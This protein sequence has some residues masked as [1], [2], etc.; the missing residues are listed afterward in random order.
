M[1]TNSIDELTRRCG[2]ATEFQNFNKEHT[3]I[4]R[5]AQE[6][7]LSS[8][9]F[10]P[11]AEGASAA[12]TQL[13]HEEWSRVLPPII[14][15]REGET[16]GFEFNLPVA[17]ADAG[18][19]CRI[20]VEEGG[21]LEQHFSPA[22][23]V[24]VA[25]HED[26]GQLYVRGS[27]TLD[28]EVLPPGHHR[29]ALLAPSS[30][31]ELADTPL[32]IAQQT[33][34]EPEPLR[35][36]GK[37]FGTTMQLYTLRSERNWGMGDFTDLKNFIIAAAP[38]GVDI[39]GLNPLHALFPA[40][41]L[42]FS[43]YSPSNRAFINVMYIDAEAVPEFAA[44]DEAQQ[45]VADTEFQ[46]GLAELRATNNVDY[47]RV[48]DYKLAVLEL[49]FEWFN[50]QELP[51]DTQRALAY[52]SFLDEQGAMLRAHATYDAMHEY[53]MGQDSDLWGWPVWPA[54][55]RDPDSDA[56]ADFVEQ[57]GDRVEYFQYLQ[58]CAF[59]Q[60]RGAQQVAVDAGMAVGVYLDL[61]VGVADSGSEAWANQHLYCLKSSA[62]AP[63][64][65]LARE[66]QDWGFPPFDPVALKHDAYELFTHNLVS[67]M[68][69]AGAVRFDHCVSLM[70]LWWVPKG[71]TARQGGY[72]NYALQDILAVLA[73][74]SWR[75][76]C[77]VIGEDLGTVPDLLTEVMLENHLY[78]YR[79]LYFE[80]EED[81]GLMIK[82]QDYPGRAVATVSTHDLPTLASWWDESDI[83]IRAELNLLG[84]D[85][86]IGK[87]RA[88][89]DEDK[90][91]LLD[92]LHE[93]GHL[94]KPLLAD[95]VPVMSDALNEAVHLY[96]AS[97][98]STVMIAQLEDWL[99]MVDP[100]NIPGT[101]EEH[102][103][104]QRKMTGPLE[105]FFD[106]PFVSKL[107]N[108]IMD[109]RLK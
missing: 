76:E 14:I 25:R 31:M 83:D 71:D 61:A 20:H 91:L 74:E 24:I 89:R 50:S 46:R 108:K 28:M 51:N 99:G 8:M 101:H 64:D 39:V 97:S 26:A 19:L 104:W 84:S 34:Y 17:Q 13:A 3:L 77:L 29:L 90:Q 102:A 103:N 85:T 75:N 95:T 96:L 55:F 21:T 105:G 22:D 36:G 7:I 49:M 15:V 43:P 5:E 27:V 79:V 10:E 70:R 78:S 93:S 56:V 23:L 67:S 41:P 37:V 72:V 4:P 73:L 32:M 48:A 106:S 57:H 98:N 11:T 38:R 52:R 42:H 12:L 16:L 68:S 82:P 30:K 60:L 6:N 86:M 80:K 2:I 18:I 40:N 94:P 63:P 66:G 109:M 88:A 62:G 45:R 33:C 35:S 9:G 107:C 59:E 65:E 53:F 92:A 1:T 87:L 54:E 58:W 81:S 100:V 47:A 44:C 69:C